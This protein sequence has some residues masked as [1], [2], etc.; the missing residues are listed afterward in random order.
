MQPIRYLHALL[1]LIL[2]SLYTG[3]VIAVEFETSI[4][5]VR[6][7][8]L[9]PDQL[10]KIA[11]LDSAEL[12]A[13]IAVYIQQDGEATIDEDAVMVMGRSEIQADNLVFHPRF[14][15]DKGPSYFVSLSLLPVDDP[16]TLEANFSF[17][18]EPRFP[19]DVPEA[20]IKVLIH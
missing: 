3:N 16:L 14:A 6:I 18:I 10:A 17:E 13:L 15:F 4:E 5:E 1:L 12:N 2:V 8:G 11:A 7:T 19:T 9:A 20:S